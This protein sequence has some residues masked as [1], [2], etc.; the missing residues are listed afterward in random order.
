MPMM[1]LVVALY[2]ICSLNDKYAVSKA[3]LNGYQLTFLMA[4]GTAF[5]LLLLMP[6]LNT[7]ISL[8]PMTFVFIILTAACKYF[9]FAMSALI[10][11]EMSVFEL[12]AW[13]GITLFMSYFT[14]VAMG[15][16]LNLL[17]AA[18]I[19]VTVCGLVLIAKAGRKS[20]SYKKIIIPLIIY[21]LSKYGY[22]F[23]MNS[24]APYASSEMTLFFALILLAAVIIPSA[25]P[26][27]IAS[28]C[29]EGRKGVVFV[30]LAKLPNAFGLMGENAVAAQSLAN[31]SFIQ[32]MILAVIFLTGLI[33][34]KNGEYEKPSRLSIWGG[35]VC[36]AGIIGFQLAGNV[37]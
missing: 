10:L 6:F 31:Y 37:I 5:F 15:Q 17:K 2:T 12:K 30:L 26:L 23:I 7:Y 16:P 35:A 3:K 34:R 4:S 25:K 28:N 24:A 14:D 19:A 36:I 29:A 9:E 1:L 32:P 33:P 18:F 13:L 22:G 20:V 8:S 27:K 11:K 21:L